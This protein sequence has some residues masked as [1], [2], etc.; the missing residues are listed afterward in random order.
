MF[1]PTRPR[2]PSISGTSLIQDLTKDQIH[3]VRVKPTL[4]KILRMNAHTARIEAG[5]VHIPR[6]SSW[7]DEF[8]KELMAFPAAPHDDQVD[9]LS[10][11]LDRAFKYH[12]PITWGTVRGLY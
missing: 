7:L 10:P 6:Q 11:A 9:A 8:R 1:V 12:H 2:T 4:E 5:C 3:A